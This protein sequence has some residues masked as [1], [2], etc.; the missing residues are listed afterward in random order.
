MFDFIEE[1]LKLK[2]AYLFFKDSIHDTAVI[3]HLAK[4]NPVQSVNDDMFFVRV[5]YYIGPVPWSTT[6][7]DEKFIDV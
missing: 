4:K 2:A 3:T 1:G 5:D 7:N 6:I